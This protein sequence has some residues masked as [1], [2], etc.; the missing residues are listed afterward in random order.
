M[1]QTVDEAVVHGV[2]HDVGYTESMPPLLD[3][4]N[5]CLG[6]LGHDSLGGIVLDGFLSVEHDAATGVLLRKAACATDGLHA[7]IGAGSGDVV[8]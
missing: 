5:V 6:V 4:G 8:L 1:A 7:A 2:V 3:G